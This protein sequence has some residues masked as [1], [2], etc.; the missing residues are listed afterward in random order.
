MTPPNPAALTADQIVAV[1][2]YVETSEDLTAAHAACDSASHTFNDDDRGRV[3]RAM[4]AAISRIWIERAPK[5]AD[6][7]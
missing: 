1:Y 2:T 3:A 4:V 6:C 7:G 5:C